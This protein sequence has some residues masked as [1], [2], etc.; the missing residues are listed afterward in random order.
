[1]WA[2]TYNKFDPASP[3]GGYKESG[4]GREGGRHGLLA[5]LKWRVMSGSMSRRPTSS[6]S[7]ASSP[8]RSRART[9][10]A[11]DEDGNVIARMAQGSR[12]DLRDA[13]RAAR[14]PRRSGRPAPATT[15]GRSSIGSPRWSRTGS[16]AFV[17]DLRAVGPRSAT[18][19]PRW[20]P[21]ST[22]S[23]G[24]PDGATSSP[25]CTATSI[26]VSRAVLQH[27]VARADRR[28]RDRRTADPP[29]G[30]RVPPGSGARAG[31]HRRGGGHGPNPVVR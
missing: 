13:V 21:P 5:Y 9:F 1:V 8:A 20:P 19:R 6:T 23:S 17:D 11:L 24:T 31:Q 14:T 26:P 25:R 18:P 28:R 29:A 12:K 27:L 10:P 4:F 3:F 2:N 16:A 30:A 22:G 15:A 7:E